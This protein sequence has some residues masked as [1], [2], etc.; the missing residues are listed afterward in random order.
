MRETI[1]TIETRGLTGAV[2]AADAMLKTATVKI[3]DFRIVGSGLVT[4]IISGDVAAVQTAVISGKSAIGNICEVVSTNVIARPHE[5][6][7]KMLC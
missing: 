6:L 4:V 1:G 2:A 5:E 7:E 3:R